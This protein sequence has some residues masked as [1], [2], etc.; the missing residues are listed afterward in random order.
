MGIKGTDFKGLRSY[1]GGFEAKD[2]YSLDSFQTWTKAKKARVRE[3]SNNIEHLLAQERRI[4]RPRNKKTL[5][6]A[7]KHSHGEIP[8]GTL[9]VAFAPFTSVMR[10]PGA[11]PVKARYKVTEAGID[12]KIGARQ[13]FQVEFDKEALVVN[14]DKEIKRV[15][16]EMPGATLFF[17]QASQFQTLRGENAKEVTSHLKQWMGKYDGVTPIKSGRHRGDAPSQHNWER[18]LDGLIGHSFDTDDYEF[19]DKDTGEI[20]YGAAGMAA[21]IDRGMQLAKARQQIIKIMKGMTEA[22]KKAYRAEFERLVSEGVPPHRAIGQASSNVKR[23]GPRK[24]G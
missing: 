13:R 1:A 5:K 2:G 17:I 12:W 3:Y 9:K 10:P 20:Y 15:M 14:P 22:Q 24:K 4:I 23:R 6:L 16:R 21:E 7:Q 8:S 18:W 11:K 19:V